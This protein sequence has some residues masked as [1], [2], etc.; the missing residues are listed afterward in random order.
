MQKAD[1]VLFVIIR[2]EGI[3]TYHFRQM[4]SLMGK[5]ANLWAHLMDDDLLTKLCGLPSGLRA[6]HAA[7]NDMKRVI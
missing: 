1:R 2:A 7:A 5:C 6:R 3:G 4:P